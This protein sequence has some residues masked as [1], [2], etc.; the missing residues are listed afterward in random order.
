MIHQLIK[1]SQPAREALAYIIR[2][3][4]L[5]FNQLFKRIKKH[6]AI[7]RKTL[8]KAIKELEA[9]GLIEAIEEPKRPWTPWRF[10]RLRDDVVK[11]AEKYA[12]QFLVKD[13]KQFILDVLASLDVIEIGEELAELYL[14]TVDPEARD[15]V[16]LS[17]S[18]D[19]FLAS[20]VILFLHLKMYIASYILS[21]LSGEDALDESFLRKLQAFVEGARHSERSRYIW[22]LL[23][24]GEILKDY[25]IVNA[26][27]FSLPLAEEAS[28]S[29]ALA[30]QAAADFLRAALGVIKDIPKPKDVKLA[31]KFSLGAFSRLLGGEAGGAGSSS[32]VG[33]EGAARPL[34]KRRRG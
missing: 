17:L 30:S 16:F 1:L 14:M 23:V 4:R 27:L 31:R 21:S 12:R 26:L 8:A 24:V 11:V 25:L 20:Y 9:T 33:D 2:E 15:I 22:S 7:S 19:P 5:S 28:E 32:K 18:D 13:G 6:R 34:E 10:Y 3:G 29:L